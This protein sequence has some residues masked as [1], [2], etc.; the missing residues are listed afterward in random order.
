MLPEDGVLRRN[1]RELFNVNFSA[2]LKLFLDYP[3]VHQLV[4][5]LC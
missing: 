2:N 5:K 4:E 1:M 3:I